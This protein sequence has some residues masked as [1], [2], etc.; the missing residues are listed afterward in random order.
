MTKRE[1]ELCGAIADFLCYSENCSFEI[2]GND[3]ELLNIV[4]TITSKR[5][6]I[7]EKVLE[8]V[9]YVNLEWD[10]YNKASFET[11]DKDE[12]LKMITEDYNRIFY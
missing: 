7:R 1:E 9:E 10:E 2:G 3:S 11:D 12:I 6:S 4:R 8:Y 5:P